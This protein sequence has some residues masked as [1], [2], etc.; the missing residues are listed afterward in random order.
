MALRLWRRSTARMAGNCTIWDTGGS[1]AR[2]PTWRVVGAQRQGVGSHESAAAQAEHS[3]ARDVAP[4]HQ[5]VAAPRFLR[6]EGR[7][8]AEEYEH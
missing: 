7:T 2:M 5:P 6:G 3:V 1:A 8:G 4:R